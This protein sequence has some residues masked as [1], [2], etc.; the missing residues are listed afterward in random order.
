MLKWQDIF[1]GRL[2]K[3]DENGDQHRQ[4]YAQVLRPVQEMYRSLLIAADERLR[5]KARVYMTLV[6]VGVACTMLA[7]TPIGWMAQAMGVSALRL[8]SSSIVKWRMPSIANLLQGSNDDFRERVNLGTEAAAQLSVMYGSGIAGGYSDDLGRL[9]KDF[10]DEL[11]TKVIEARSHLP[12]AD[13]AD[14]CGTFDSQDHQKI[15]LKIQAL[16][17]KGAKPNVVALQQAEIDRKKGLMAKMQTKALDEKTC[18]KIATSGFYGAT[19]DYKYT[20]LVFVDAKPRA[21]ASEEMNSVRMSWQG[22][23]GVNPDSNALI[24]F[25]GRTINHLKAFW[26]GGFTEPKES[27]GLI[28]VK[29]LRELLS[30]RAAGSCAPIPMAIYELNGKTTRYLV[31]TLISEGNTV[32]AALFA[33][34]DLSAAGVD[35]RGIV[36]IET[37]KLTSA[38]N[39]ANGAGRPEDVGSTQLNQTFVEIGR[40]LKEEE[41]FVDVAAPTSKDTAF[42]SSLIQPK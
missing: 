14:I 42:L 10:T 38:G 29:S 8:N 12:A 33:L 5:Y 18:S 30:H 41:L 31:S 35:D 11:V 36:R 28:Q 21:A 23:N 9:A 40:E 17:I 2:T 24:R 32:S 27:L 1:A 16:L 34:Y 37:A 3:P 15:C 39:I 20:P 19:D 6:S 4:S 25:S 7:F 13:P 22:L 26:N